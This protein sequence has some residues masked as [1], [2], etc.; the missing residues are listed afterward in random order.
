MSAN[1]TEEMRLTAT[2]SSSPS[3]CTVRVSPS[4]NKRSNSRMSAAFSGGMS[5]RLFPR[6]FFSGD[7]KEVASPSWTL[8]ARSGALRLVSSPM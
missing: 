3:S 1:S 5:R 7:Q 4:A 6:L 8:P 2:S